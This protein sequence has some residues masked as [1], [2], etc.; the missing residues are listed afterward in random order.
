M[1]FSS[2]VKYNA[3]ENRRQVGVYEKD[4]R[5]NGRYVAEYL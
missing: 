5:E 3:M 1:C 4:V 2:F